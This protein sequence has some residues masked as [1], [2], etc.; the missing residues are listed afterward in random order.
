[1]SEAFRFF[2]Y[3]FVNI[4]IW[5]TYQADDFTVFSV[6][7]WP[8]SLSVTQWFPVRLASGGLWSDLHCSKYLFDFIDIN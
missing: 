1:M 3:V 5:S 7:N 8:I 4:M 2:F 6:N